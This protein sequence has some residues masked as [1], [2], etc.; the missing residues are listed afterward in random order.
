MTES[1]NTQQPKQFNILLIGDDC[2]DVY[3]YGTVDRISP[4]APVPVFTLS[5]EE[6]KPGMAHN[7]MKNL[8]ALGCNVTYLATKESSTK[9]RLIDIRSKQQ[10][11][12]I[13]LDAKP[14]PIEFDTAIPPIYDAI[15]ISDYNKGS[16]TYELIEELRREFKGPIFVDT[17]KTDLSRFEG[18]VIKINQSEYQKAV[19]FATDMI[20]TQGAKGAIYQ[21]NI[22]MSPIVEVA[23]VCGA[24][25]TF[26]S[27]LVYK[28]LE[29]DSIDIAINFANRASAVTV[30]HI[31]VYAPTLEEIA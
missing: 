2:I 13:D 10:I 4:E 27:A 6:R 14:I 16:V 19:S 20:I 15:V 5:Y 28:Y 21:G 12:R 9:T 18:C 8:E 23:D 29:T 11:V 26:L 17:K 3:Q 25:D 24:G 30:Q 22:I 31:G 1:N 7:V